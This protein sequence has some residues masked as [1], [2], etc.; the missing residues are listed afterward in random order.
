MLQVGRQFGSIDS[1]AAVANDD[2]T[3]MVCYATGN[4]TS[5]LR[6]MKRDLPICGMAR[7]NAELNGRSWMLLA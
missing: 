3:A 6:M 5:I 1:G 2:E 7:T 4:S